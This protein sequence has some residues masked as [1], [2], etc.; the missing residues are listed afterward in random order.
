MEIVDVGDSTIL[1][2]LLQLCDR[3]GSDFR[4]SV[5]KEDSEQ[6]RPSILVLRNGEIVKDLSKRIENGDHLVIS[7]ISA[8]G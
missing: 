8:G 3:Y 4:K 6:V 1:S 5:L 2:L 7:T